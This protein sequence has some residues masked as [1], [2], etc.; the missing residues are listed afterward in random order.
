MEAKLI[1]FLEA[2]IEDYNYYNEENPEQ[3]SAEW[4]CMAEMERVFAD[5]S[6]PLFVCLQG[7]ERDI[8]ELRKLRLC[9]SCP[10]SGCL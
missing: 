5:I 6:L 9:K 10:L 8:R 1:K 7:F 4:G 3:G 2:V